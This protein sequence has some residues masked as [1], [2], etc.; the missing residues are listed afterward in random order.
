VPATLKQVMPVRTRTATGTRP[1]A[2]LLLAIFVGVVALQLAT[3]GR[4]MAHTRLVSSSPAKGAKLDRLPE[5]AKLTFAEVVFQ[6]AALTVTGPD[7]AEVSTGKVALLDGTLSRPLAATADP[8]PGIYTVSYQ[9]TSADGH[10]VSGTVTFTVSGGRATPTD[11]PAMA[12]R[13]GRQ[14]GVNRSLASSSP[15]NGAE[16][17]WLPEVAVLNFS[18][19]IRQPAAVTVTG[20]D[21]DDISIADASVVDATLLRPVD[22]TIEPAAGA[23]T[24]SYRVTSAR[25]QRLSGSVTFTLAAGAAVL[26]TGRLATVGDP[27]VAHTPGSGAAVALV[28]GLLAALGVV[29]ASIGRLVR[30]ESRA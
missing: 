25:G 5:A 10:P 14:V 7:R 13:Q 23:Y 22:T 8:R 11:D 24:I 20:P 17:G 19:A 4:A 30:D 1:A 26:G 2:A 6:P 21:G 12:G 3:A 18:E 9:V 16:L 28:V 29:V 15:A 27:P